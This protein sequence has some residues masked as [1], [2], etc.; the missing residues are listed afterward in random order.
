M[1]NPPTT[2]LSAAQVIGVRVP[3]LL[4][5]WDEHNR[6]DRPDD[7]DDDDDDDDGDE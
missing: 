4:L 7:G 1:Y 5:G 3:L 2:W 6:R